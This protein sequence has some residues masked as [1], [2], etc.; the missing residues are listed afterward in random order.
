MEQLLQ[1]SKEQLL[2]PLGEARRKLLII[3]NFVYCVLTP[4]FL[5][6]EKIATGKFA[7]DDRLLAVYCTAMLLNLCSAIYNIIIF[8]RL[9]G[10]SILKNI[11]YEDHAIYRHQRKLDMVFG[12]IS[13]VP[14]LVMSFLNQIGFGNPFGDALLTDFALAHSLMIVVVLILGRVAVAIWFAVVMSVLIFTVERRGWDYQYHYATPSEVQK[15]Q[16]GLKAGER[17]AIERQAELQRER[18]VS[19][20]ITRYFNTWSIFLVVG[21]LTA[22]FFSGITVD[23]FK[24]VPT[25]VGNIEN[26]LESSKKMELEQKAYEDKTNTFINLAHETKTPLTLINNYLNEYIQKNGMQRDEDLTVL[27]A[28]IE[29]LTADMINFFDI[30]RLDR[31]FDI[32]DHNQITNI[33]KIVSMKIP[34]FK[35]LAE[36][37]GIR[38]E[39]KAVPDLY[40]IAHPG[41]VERIINNLIENSI[42][43][44][45]EG[46]VVTV[47]LGATESVV[48]FRVRDTGIGIPDTLHEKIFEPYFQLSTARKN[49]DGMGLGLSI[50]KKIVSNLGGQISMK[51]QEMSGTEVAVSVMKYIPEAGFNE[52]QYNVDNG[53]GLYMISGIITDRL[54]DSSKPY[55]L[56]IE[57]NL[58]MLSYLVDKLKS[59]YNVYAAKSGEEALEKLN[60]I[61]QLEL[62]ISDVMME[63][64]DG[65]EFCRELY[66]R[67]KYEH[68]P[69]IFLTAKTTSDDKMLGLSLGAID[70]I[71]KPFLISQLIQKIDSV[72][73]N[74]KKQQVA[75]IKRAS[76]LLSIEY[77]QR[78]RA[79]NDIIISDYDANCKRYGL[80]VREIEIVNLLITGQPY[81]IIGD[82]LNISVNTVAKHIS[83]VFQKVKANNK[84][85]LMNKL[86]E[87]SH[88][89]SGNHS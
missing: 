4:F 24:I 45:P 78:G 71:E 88:V 53:T 31:G 46:G 12:Y 41:A 51:S 8:K 27:K 89:P 23:I 61:S 32:Y 20:R 72:L 56:I 26:A 76:R 65:F 18:L 84:V 35:N 13:M 64:M 87:P 68:I 29:K 14:I 74:F 21:F 30:E 15:F 19:P 44:T 66:K 75:L 69:V 70:Y 81:K 49:N 28:N 73:V 48:E 77:E 37:K 10:K 36:K 34:L 55:I 1:R 43:Y 85:E 2:N 39:V 62:I 82:S 79:I 80:T 3:L 25:V 9:K 50:V 17:W 5:I 6:S 58:S 42:K 7:N 11:F 67:E 86:H 63:P 83:N 60:A 59:R 16:A 57:D 40:T 22:Y 47:E 33:S 38:L 52:E 54:S